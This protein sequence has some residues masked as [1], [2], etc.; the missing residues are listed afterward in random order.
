MQLKLGSTTFEKFT[1]FCINLKTLKNEQ[2]M[3]KYV[4]TCAI[5]IARYKRKLDI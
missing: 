4:E 1:F 2:S 3:E 5:I